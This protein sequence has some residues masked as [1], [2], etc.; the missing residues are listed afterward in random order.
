LLI[1]IKF[2][3]Q[4]GVD[5]LL[6]LTRPR[7][8]PARVLIVRLDGIG[9]FVLWLDAARTTAN[10]YKAQGKRV[11]LVANA[12]WAEWVRDL[13][14][15]D[16]VIALD[17]RRFDNEWKYRWR[18]G[19]RV[20]MLGCSMAVNPTFSREW[21][22]GDA[23]VRVCGARERIGSSGD[24]SNI[25]SW[26]RR[27]SNRAYT[28]LIPAGPSPCMEL[29]RNA[30]FLRGLGAADYLARVADL[31]AM[32]A[33]RPDDAFVAANGRDRPYYVFF[34]GSG[35]RGKRWPLACFVELA[36]QLY[37]RTGWRGVVCGGPEDVELAETLCT[38]AAGAA[39]LNWAG[40]TDLA[41]LAAIISG[42]RLLVAN[43]TSATHIAAACGVPGA[44]IVGGGHNDRFLPYRVERIDGRPLP[45]VII[46]RMPCFG[47]NWQCIYG[48]P[49]GGPYPCIEGVTV[50]AVWREISE[51]LEL[52]IAKNS[53]TAHVTSGDDDVVSGEALRP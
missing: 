25:A 16:D 14:V 11:I 7:R 43:D 35:V 20:R 34:P 21:L 41:Q 42:G 48:V 4:F 39:L 45:R 29:L 40:R 9:D 18:F 26:Q 17:R 30:E 22:F 44:C 23:V 32:S 36:D 2:A 1:R 3:A 6:L 13:G 8:R 12:L 53:S 31:H 33:L 15:F 49:L 19:H 24:L 51:I 5:T 46:H 27:L 28:R 50:P 47:C 37:R 10:L 52:I 38:Q